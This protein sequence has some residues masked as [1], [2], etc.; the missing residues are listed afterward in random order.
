MSKIKHSKNI[1]IETY[2]NI[3]PDTLCDW[4]V[5][6]FNYLQAQ[7]DNKIY[8]AQTAY[9][10]YPNYFEAT[11]F[12]L[13]KELFEYMDKVE[14]IDNAI[15]ECLEHYLDKYSI[16]P[17][18]KKTCGYFKQLSDWVVQKYSVEHKEG[19]HSY[20]TDWEGN[21]GNI[22]RRGAALIVYLNDVEEGGETEFFFQ[23]VKIKPKKGTVAIFPAYYTH[24]HKGHIPISNDKFVLLNWH[25]IGLDF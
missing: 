4:I 15:D 20:H 24:A 2:D 25:T 23:G 19:Y 14:I 8:R 6:E 5:S 18:K 9:G 7:S 11:N 10:N 3:I 16:Q 1:F 17:E 22:I 13:R 12:V 21:N